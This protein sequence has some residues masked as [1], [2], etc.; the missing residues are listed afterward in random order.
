M[1]S[2]PD[3]ATPSPHP[4][5]QVMSRLTLLAA[6]SALLLGW[7][8]RADDEDPDPSPVPDLAVKK[9]DDAASDP[10]KFGGNKAVDQKREQL[11]ARLKK[12]HDGL[13]R[14]GQDKQAGEL[15]E[16]I[17]LAETL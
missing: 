17:L 6:C 5:G 14:R 13:V 16:R 1:P 12:Q 4:G 8:V 9:L 10:D 11:V 3:E 7:A 2:F 15:M